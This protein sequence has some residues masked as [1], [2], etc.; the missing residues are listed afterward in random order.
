MEC[1]DHS[2]RTRHGWALMAPERLG[3][4]G[5]LEEKVAILEAQL[6]EIDTE[7]S[8]RTSDHQMILAALERARDTYTSA[9][10]DENA[11]GESSLGNNYTERRQRMHQIIRGVNT[12]IFD[13]I[14]VYSSFLKSLNAE[15]RQIQRAIAT[16]RLRMRLLA[17]E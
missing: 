1:G 10:S 5:Y 8:S 12:G 17:G 2:R 6:Q 13:E 16:L 15:K 14:R 9:L 11:L 3:P 4:R 7:V